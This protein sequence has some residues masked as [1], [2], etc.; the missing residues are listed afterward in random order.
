MCDFECSVS[1]AAKQALTFIG[2]LVDLNPARANFFVGPIVGIG[3]IV[4]LLFKPGRDPY[5]IDE[6]SRLAD[7]QSSASFPSASRSSL[8]LAL[9][10]PDMFS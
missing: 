5:Q 4:S 7:V 9:A 2:N 1:N 10:V 3:P 8:P 6:C